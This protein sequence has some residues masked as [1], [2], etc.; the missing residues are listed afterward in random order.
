MF[1]RIRMLNLTELLV[2]KYIF[3]GFARK[4]MANIFEKIIL[5]IDYF[6]ETDGLEIE[7]R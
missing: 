4:V 7:Y 6:K 1:R 2:Q 5:H 3:V